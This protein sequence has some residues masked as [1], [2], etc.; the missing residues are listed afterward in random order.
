MLYGFWARVLRAGRALWRVLP[1]AVQ[2]K[3]APA[4]DYLHRAVRLKALSFDSYSQ[5]RR[6]ILPKS[7]PGRGSEHR[8]EHA[9]IEL[10]F[11]RDSKEGSDSNRAPVTEG[12]GAWLLVCIRGAKI[13]PWTPPHLRGIVN[14]QE[15]QAAVV[16]YV[17]DHE[18]VSDSGNVDPVFM[19]PGYF[20]PDF[21]GPVPAAIYM[22]AEAYFEWQHAH[23]REA[24]YQNLWH[25]LRENHFAAIA[26]APGMIATLPANLAVQ[27]DGRT[28]EPGEEMEEEGVAPTVSIIIPTRDQLHHLKRCIDSLDTHDAGASYE[29]IVVDNQSVEAETQVFL[30]DLRSKPGYSVLP[31]DA[32]FNYAAIN[33]MAADS[34]HG[35]YILLLNNDTEITHAGWLR[36]LLVHAARADVGAVGAQLLYPDGRLQHAGVTIG[37]GGLAGHP[38]R[39]Q[40]RAMQPWNQE[41][42]HSRLVSAVTAACLLVRASV[43]REVG[44]LDEDNFPVAFN[45]VDFCLKCRAA[46]YHNIIEPSVCLIHHESVS[47]GADTTPEKAA[48]FAREAAALQTRWSTD[49]VTDVYYHPYLCHAGETVTLAAEPK[50]HWGWERSAKARTIYT[51][52]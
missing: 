46:G 50:P 32:P 15:G 21:S 18:V 44:G 11:E 4:A 6:R 2:Q 45:D 22:K 1:R 14:S 28:T 47:R 16:A 43:F 10:P 29:V 23:I 13:Q 5:W 19:H 24:T 20:H 12:V 41:L 51:P 40:A 49:K 35:T 48:R 42:N 39:F 37:L 17:G 36:G 30:D 7:F 31:Y 27:C 9:A 8:D 33:N 25:W 38:Y 34:A 52:Y 26:H 3:L